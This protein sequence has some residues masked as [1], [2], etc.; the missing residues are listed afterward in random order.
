MVFSNDNDK[1][2]M[3]T[4]NELHSQNSLKQQKDT[5]I[6]DESKLNNQNSTFLNV[7]SHKNRGRKVSFGGISSFPIVSTGNKLSLANCIIQDTNDNVIANDK[8][9]DNNKNTSCNSEKNKIDKTN[10]NKLNE[11]KNNYSIQNFVDDI[12][13]NVMKNVMDEKND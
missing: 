8:T 12:L 3:K 1:K 10:E 11:Y 9:I 13:L 4:K 6:L 5:K 7:T 2:D